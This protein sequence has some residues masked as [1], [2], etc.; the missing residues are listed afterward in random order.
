MTIKALSTFAVMDVI[1]TV[2]TPI[3]LSQEERERLWAEHY[4]YNKDNKT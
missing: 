3:I 1:S 4:M 2:Y